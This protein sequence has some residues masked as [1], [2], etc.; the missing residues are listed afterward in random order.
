M[1]SN[2]ELID[3]NDLF[4]CKAILVSLNYFY[5]LVPKGLREP[6]DSPALFKQI[7]AKLYLMRY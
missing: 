5:C 2:D 1:V 3:V 4:F 6:S 7:A